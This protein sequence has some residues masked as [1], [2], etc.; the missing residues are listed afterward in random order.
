MAH[1]AELNIAKLKHPIDHPA[2]ADFVAAIDG[3][4]AVAERS[5][6]FVWRFMDE[7]GNATAVRGPFD[8]PMTI[9]NMSVW[10]SPEALE[11]FT[12]N[13]VHKRVYE[14]KAKWFDAME[15]HHLVMWW[16]EE[17]HRPT[18]EEAADRLALLDAQGS[19]DE[20]F[21]WSHLP[22]VKLWQTQRC[23]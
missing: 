17:G 23:A 5:P 8:D 15:S 11:H 7:S 12:W 19:T 21:T 14:K 9:V 2:I 3:I 16:V 1:L 18:L 6:G 20:A 10:E 4:N 22:H 13:T